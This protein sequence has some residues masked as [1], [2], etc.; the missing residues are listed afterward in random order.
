MGALQLN[1]NFTIELCQTADRSAFL[2]QEKMS[3]GF[4]KST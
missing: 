1:Y 3:N 2:V 4:Y